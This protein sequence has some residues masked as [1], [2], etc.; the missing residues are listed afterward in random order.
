MRR[1]L[2]KK[3]LNETYKFYI[4]WYLDAKT[5]SEG[6][7]GTVDVYLASPLKEDILSNVIPTG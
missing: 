6:T 3:E 4:E 1:V 7:D 2:T 5:Y